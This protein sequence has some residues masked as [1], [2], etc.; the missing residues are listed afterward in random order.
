MKYTVCPSGPLPVPP[1]P[2]S[3]DAQAGA[4][5][6]LSIIT[7]MLSRC[8]L[9]HDVGY[10]ESGHTSSL[11]MLVMADE[12]VAMSRYFVEGLSI[13]DEP[14]PWTPSTVWRAAA[15]MAP[16]SS[17]TPTPSTISSSHSSTR[18][19]PIAAASNSGTKWAPKRCISDAMKGPGG[20]WPI[21]GSFPNPMQ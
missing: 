8:N 10:I 16:S 1:I 7:A 17:A 21:T 11:E 14:W 12:L 9:I 3:L 20:F 13:D 15:A 18:S 4:E 2:K 6:M 19:W 5:G